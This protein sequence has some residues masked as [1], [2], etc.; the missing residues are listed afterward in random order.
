MSSTNLEIWQFLKKQLKPRSLDPS[1]LLP[2]NYDPSIK[3]IRCTEFSSLLDCLREKLQ[4]HESMEHTFAVMLASHIGTFT[5]SVPL[6]FYIIGPASS[7]KTTLSDLISAASPYIKAVSKFTGLHSGFRS[8]A[9]KADASLFASWQN[10]TVVIKDFTT[11]IAMSPEAR[12]RIFSE[13]RDAYDGSSAAQFRNRVAHEYHGI[14]FSVLAC[15]TEAIRKFNVSN[16]GERFLHCQID[17]RWNPDLTLTTYS[18]S[19]DTLYRAMRSA[20]SSITDD[21]GTSNSHLIPQKCTT[22]GFIEYLIQS[23]ENNPDHVLRIGNNISHKYLPF[24]MSMSKIVSASRAYVDGASH[25]PRPE[26]ATRVAIQLSKLAACLC[27]VYGVSSPDKTILNILRKVAYDTSFNLNSEVMMYIYSNPKTTIPDIVSDVDS[28]A[29]T[30]SKVISDL[31][32]LGI[33]SK[34][35][36]V[37]RSIGR[38]AMS[39]DL[40]KEIRDSY[41]IIEETTA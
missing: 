6:W 37:K 29:P 19:D 31:Q 1:E 39:Y 35:T 38:P 36:A 5:G 40:V 9:S 4:I 16:L 7:G 11:V 34:V 26:A 10:M 28:T 12:D 13:L 21:K 32:A 20:L 8:G 30:I 24:L 15:V 22:Y 18:A 25:R 27:I 17:S 2:E 41:K 3:P 14:K 33:V 23:I